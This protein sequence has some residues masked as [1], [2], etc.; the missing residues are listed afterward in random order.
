[1]NAEQQS[2]DLKILWLNE[3]SV[4]PYDSTIDYPVDA[5]TIKDGVF[6]IFNGSVWEVYATASYWKHAGIT[7]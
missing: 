6:K 5:V 1:M 2:T 4:T 7:I 3:N